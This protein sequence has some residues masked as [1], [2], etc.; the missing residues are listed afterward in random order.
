MADAELMAT[1]IQDLELDHPWG[2]SPEEALEIAIECESTARE[3]EKI[4]N[5][6]GATLTTSRGTTIYANSHD[7]VGSYSS[8][9]HNL[10][11]IVVAEQNGGMQRDY[12]YADNTQCKTT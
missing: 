2:I 3:N 12:W 11:C 4:S 7:F 8:T 10:S 6:E 5:S 1:E 9:R